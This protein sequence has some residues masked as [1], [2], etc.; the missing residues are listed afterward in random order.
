MDANYSL[1]H[2]RVN[3]VERHL[4]QFLRA[5]KE[6]IARGADGARVELTYGTSRTVGSES[7]KQ[8]F[9][10]IRPFA[11]PDAAARKLMEIASGIGPV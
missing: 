2:E 9:V 6:R 8:N 3:A 4:H 7:F 1:E 11:D 10:E 5:A